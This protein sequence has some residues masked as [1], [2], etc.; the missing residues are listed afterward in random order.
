MPRD[1]ERPQLSER[2]ATV[3]EDLRRALREGFVSFRELSVR[4]RISEKDIAQH[5]EH[6]ARS[7]KASGERLDVEPA[8]CLG[9]EFVFKDR[10]RLTKPSRCPRCRGERLAAARF[11]IVPRGAG[12][13][14]DSAP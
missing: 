7:V 5:L 2:Q 8:Q 13:S 1:R 4:V 14:G 9:C 12:H 10:T 6:L 11:R 3:R